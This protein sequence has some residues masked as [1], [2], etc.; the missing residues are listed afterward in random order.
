MGTPE[1]IHRLPADLAMR[2]AGVPLAAA[3]AAA[4]AAA[5]W[6]SSGTSVINL[7]K[8]IKDKK[9]TAKLL[10]RLEDKKGERLNAQDRA[11]ITR[12][13]N[14][15]DPSDQKKVISKAKALGKRAERDKKKAEEKA[16]A[17]KDRAQRKEERK[18][19]PKKT[20]KDRVKQVRERTTKQDV[21]RTFDVVVRN[22]SA[23][24]SL[25]VAK[26]TKKLTKA[27]SKSKGVWKEIA[28]AGLKGGGKIGLKA[29]GRITGPLMAIWDV[30][31]GTSNIA[32]MVREHN[33]DKSL[34]KAF[35]KPYSK[36]TK[37][38]K[39]QLAEAV[40]KLDP[41]VQRMLVKDT[42]LLAD[43]AQKKKKKEAK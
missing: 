6:Y 24:Q 15:L 1:L 16:K 37:A 23:R 27:L 19:A 8:G 20:V 26:N 13:L 43:A 9:K 41:Q 17:K 14:S 3:A 22:M 12:V 30:A 25:D 32:K 34:A 4:M 21:E 18:N 35:E 42:L 11:H 36:R 31:D 38:E 39:E 5:F 10:A 29:A 28:K 2:Q 33:T 7:V 40:S